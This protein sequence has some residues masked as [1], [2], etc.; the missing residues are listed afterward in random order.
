MVDTET[1]LDMVRDMSARIEAL[2]KKVA[3]LEDKQA[4]YERDATLTSLRLWPLGVPRA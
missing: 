1:Y 2:E 3:E 4:Q